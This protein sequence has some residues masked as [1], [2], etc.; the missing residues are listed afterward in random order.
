[1]VP[2]SRNAGSRVRCVGKSVGVDTPLSFRI[3]VFTH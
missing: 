1:V 3:I 2:A